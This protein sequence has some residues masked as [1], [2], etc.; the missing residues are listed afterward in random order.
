MQ[1]KFKK[2]NDK[3]QLPVYATKEAAGMDLYACL[4][5][6]VTLRPGEAAAV[7]TG[8]AMELPPGMEAQIR[9]R[10]GLAFKHAVFS[11]NGTIDSDYRGEIKVLLI[12]HSRVPFVIEPGMRICQMVVN[13]SYVKCRPEFSEELNETERGENGFGSTGEFALTEDDFDDEGDVPDHVQALHATSQ[14]TPTKDEIMKKLF[15]ASKGIR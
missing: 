5:E 15:M 8:L 12:N 2:L 9:G 13:A 10:S 14:P 3:A 6:P 11:Y 1:L 4:D 7:P